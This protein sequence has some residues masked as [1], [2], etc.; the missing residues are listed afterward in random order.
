MLTM[1]DLLAQTRTSFRSCIYVGLPLCKC[2]GY[3]L[4]I[5]GNFSYQLVDLFCFLSICF[6]WVGGLCVI[7]NVTCI[8]CVV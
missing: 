7:S 2:A 3:L 5:D 1:F 8:R 6:F 4:H